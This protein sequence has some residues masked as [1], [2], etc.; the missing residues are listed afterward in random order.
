[1]AQKTE[2][3]SQDVVDR[4]NSYQLKLNDLVLNLGQVHLRTRELKNEIN[5]VDE[6]KSSMETQFDAINLEL[7]EMLSNLEKMY[8]NGELDLKEGIV[9]F[10]SAE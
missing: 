9:T 6:L 4:L 2:K 8:P 7:N 1:M 3:L 5:K 10:E